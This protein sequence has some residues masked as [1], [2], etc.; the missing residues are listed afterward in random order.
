MYM[1]NTICMHSFNIDA[2]SAVNSIERMRFGVPSAGWDDLES[3][4]LGDLSFLQ[5]AD[6][7]GD[8]GSSQLPHAM[9]AAAPTECPHTV[10]VTHPVAGGP[11]TTAVQP[12]PVAGRP[13]IAPCT[14][15]GA[16]S[17]P[18]RDGAVRGR[19]AGEQRICVST[20]PSHRALA[21]AWYVV[22]ARTR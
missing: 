22:R 21:H 17:P 13:C 5:E 12:Q 15:S 14:P 9:Q 16:M 18:A 20:R 19:A 11:S 1:L 2:P 7:A 3:L 6:G 10:H 4:D 8:Q